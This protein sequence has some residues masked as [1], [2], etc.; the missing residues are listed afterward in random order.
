MKVHNRKL[1]K[2]KEI[3]FYDEF[4]MNFE[5]AIFSKSLNIKAISLFAYT[6]LNVRKMACYNSIFKF[7]VNN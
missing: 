3:I 2:N 7:F 6:L 1:L 5:G 4:L